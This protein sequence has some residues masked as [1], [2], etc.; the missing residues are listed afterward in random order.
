M[1]K[2]T[3]A[4]KTSVVQGLTI[5]S[6]GAFFEDYFIIEFIIELCYRV[7]WKYKGGINLLE[8]GGKAGIE[9]NTLLDFILEV[10]ILKAE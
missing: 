2:W 4:V 10:I 1:F 5:Y 6:K 7:L 8:G 9:K 3:Q